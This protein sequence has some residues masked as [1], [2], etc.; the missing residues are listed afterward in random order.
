M[1]VETVSIRDLSPADVRCWNAWAAP[2]GQLVSP[3]LLHDFAAAVDGVRNDVRVTVAR[4][5]GEAIGFF[6][7]HAPRGGVVRPVGSPMSDYQGILCAP[8]RSLHPRDMLAGA[9][10][11]ALVYDNWL[12]AGQDLSRE[13][14]ERDGSVVCDVNAG[15]EAFLAAQSALHKDHYKKIARR[16][17]QAE[18]DFGPAHFVFGDPTGDHYATLKAWKGRQYRA[19]GKLDVLSVG[20]ADRLLGDLRRR[21]G[22]EFG[23]LTAALYFG[24]RLAAV[25]IG[26]K[27]GGVYH[28][29]FPA[30]DSEFARVSP[31]LLLIHGII[32]HAERLGL[33]RIDLGRGHAQYKKYYASYE[34]PLD[35]GRVL[36]TGIAALA[37]R[38]WETAEACARILPPNIAEIPTRAR[39]RWAQISA[40]EPDLAARL[41]TLARSLKSDPQAA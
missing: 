22:S 7:H 40:F 37:I 26:L 20:W 10:A 35:T 25:E 12:T 38:G 14:R 11:C 9:G 8:G 30:Y 41:G 6:A 32:E 13:R 21:E 27:A 3:Y 39:R 24:E 2:G 18:R 34:V 33:A 28:S 5:N 4:E 1:R 29:W 36:D 17:R 16:L 23:T 15:G 19:T 31:G